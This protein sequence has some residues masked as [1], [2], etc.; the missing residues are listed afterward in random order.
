MA[1][2]VSRSIK[3][4]LHSIVID[5]QDG[6]FTLDLDG[7]GGSRPGV[8][9]SS[10]AFI[11]RL[12]RENNDG[13]F[14]LETNLN[15]NT[16]DIITWINS[17][18]FEILYKDSDPLS[19]GA[20]ITTTTVTIQIVDATGAA[21]PFSNVLSVTVTDTGGGTAPGRVINTTQPV[22]FIRS[23]N[24]RLYEAKVSISVTGTGSFILG[25]TDSAGTGLVVTDTLTV[26]FT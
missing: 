5:N 4:L 21:N 15:T 18:D 1:K 12:L 8:I 3:A 2:A 16:D 22:S 20:G 19:P 9:D 7:V 24:P 11:R 17:R 25:L 23:F 26:N 10:K 6:T 13:T 14:R